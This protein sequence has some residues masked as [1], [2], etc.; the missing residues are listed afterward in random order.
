[1][2]TAKKLARFGP[3][4]R[5]LLIGRGRDRLRRWN[6]KYFSGL[7]LFGWA[8]LL[9]NGP[10]LFAGEQGVTPFETF[11]ALM[12]AKCDG[13]VLEANGQVLQRDV[14]RFTFTKGTFYFL[15]PV[16]GRTFG[17]IFIGEGTYRLSPWRENERRQLNLS[18]WFAYDEVL[19]EP[20]QALHLLFSDDSIAAL[21][22]ADG[23]GQAA[24]EPGNRQLEK[25]RTM[26]AEKFFTNF[27][28]RLVQSLTNGGRAGS[29]G[30][31]AA[32][33]DFRKLP[34]ALAAVD[35]IGAGYL[36]GSTS[37]L[38]PDQSVFYV[39][40]DLKGGYWYLDQTAKPGS[41]QQ[42]RTQRPFRY[43]D[44]QHYDIETT[45]SGRENIT[46]TTRVRFE[47][48]SPQLSVLPL[49]LSGRNE[50]TG[51][52]LTS[53][54]ASAPAAA[55]Y[56]GYD[57]AVF[58][59]QPL[60][61]G[62]VYELEIQTFSRK[63]LAELVD[64]LFTVASR[65]SWYP[66]LGVFTDKATFRLL[67]RFPKAQE[68]VSVGTLVRDEDED[69]KRITE[70]VCRTPVNVAGFN[71]GKLLVEQQKEEM[72][73]L[74]LSLYYGRQTPENIRFNIMADAVNSA[75]L[76]TNYF[77]PLPYNRIS[78]SQQ[79]EIDF[80]QAWPTL[81][82]LPYLSFIGG[83][84]I[85]SVSR[86][87]GIFFHEEVTPHEMA[88]QWWGHQITAASYRDQ[89]LEEGIAE[90]AAGLL[91]EATQGS[92][93]MSRFWAV[94]ATDILAKSPYSKLKNAETGPISQG[95]RLTTNKSRTGY[96]T[97]VYSKGAF[98]VH[99]L[100]MMMQD[101]GQDPDARFKAMLQEFIRTSQ[102]LPVNTH[103]FQKIVEKYMTPQMLSL[104][105]GR[106]MTWFFDQWVYGVTI[107]RYE[108]KIKIK[109]AE[110]GKFQLLGT[111]TQSEVTPGFRMPVPIYADFGKG[112]LVRLGAVPLTG[113]SSYELDITLAMPKKPKKI[114]VNGRHDILARGK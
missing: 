13:R 39:S 107:P 79:T 97:L 63:I 32:L 11:Q 42:N 18:S 21:T 57:A 71:Y 51:L 9:A 40:H 108:T 10:L 62:K 54:E 30:L 33:I 84:Q 44:A 34:P 61:M 78:I 102:G 112:Q 99:M 14:H 36:M 45:I 38:D 83:T 46:G 77:G 75:R 20:F 60:Q 8:C 114:V 53:A 31:F 28:L 48:T 59:A 110:Q 68:I 19:E 2:L 6:L 41:E 37:R 96:Q 67:F 29:E 100:R 70:W 76:F 24:A 88:H 7:W 52:K 35:P 94:R 23:I 15:Q 109:K 22:T 55:M 66:N 104:S 85:N 82:F 86:E 56:H 113:N 58:F 5:M 106:D 50:I 95:F 92:K 1:M 103:D 81:V 25:F 105:G 16:Q 69:G 3:I 87:A 47:V 4:F 17:L 72:S 27:E 43:V 65:T 111:I 26:A 64:G 90:F 73:Q 80:G 74:D 93:R 49:H 89:W 91:V 12:K 98:V 101:K